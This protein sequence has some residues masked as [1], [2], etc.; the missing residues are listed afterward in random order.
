[1]HELIEKYGTIG[2]VITEEQEFPILNIPMVSDEKW[3][4]MAKESA[5]RNFAKMNGRNPLD[6]EEALRWQRSLVRSLTG[7]A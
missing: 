4:R 1:M 6:V 2:T 7:T 3:Q 5:V